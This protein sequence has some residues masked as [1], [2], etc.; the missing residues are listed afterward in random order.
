[1]S[2]R[3][4]I[5]N[6]RNIGIM[7]HIDAG[8]TTTTERILYYTG[9]SYKIG[10]VHD[11]TAIMDWMAQEQERG[12]TITSAA[13]TCVWNGHTINIIDTPGHVDFTI[14]VER[15]LRVLDGAIAVLDG[16]AGVEPQTETVWRQADKYSVP[17]I[18]FVNKMDRVGADFDACVGMVQQRLEVVPFVVQR[19]I[20]VEDAFAGVIDLVQMDKI[21]WD[22]GNLGSTFKR[23][24]LGVEE[25]VEA[26]IHREALLEQLSDFDDELLEMILEGEEPSVDCL[27][28]VLRK[29]TLSGDGV[30]VLC[31]AAFK[32]KGVQPLLDA[33]L[34]YLPSPTDVPPVEGLRVDSKT[35]TD[36]TVT[37]TASDEAPFSALA[38]KIQSDKFVDQL[39]YFRVYSG[40]LAKGKT[41][42]N[43]GKGKRERI[44]RLLKMHANQQEEV[45]VCYAGDIVAAVGLRLVTTGDTLC[46]EKDRIILE[47]IEFPDPVIRI[48]IEPRTK[49]DQDKLASALKRLALED[50]SFTVTANSETGQ[51]V[52]AGMGELHLE[53]IVDRLLREFKVKANR[54][55]PQV[56]YRE[57]VGSQGLAEGKFVRQN[58]GKGQFGHCWLTVEPGPLGSGF[59]FVS[60]MEAGMI[61]DG[62]IPAIQDGAE[63]AYQSGSLAG[64]PM[65]DVLVTLTKASFHEVDSTEAAFKIAGSIA[66]RAACDRATPTLLEPLMGVEIV[67]PEEFLGDVISDVNQRGGEVRNMEPRGRLQAVTAN[68]PL[69][70][71]FG[72]STDLRSATQ[73]RATYS[74]EFERYSPV[75]KRVLDTIVGVH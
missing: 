36:V 28:A 49:V 34:L 42:Y 69:S 25:G 38:F 35:V 68:I 19:P 50:P 18:L 45:A 60:T 27:N 74:M 53:I 1:M 46:S 51:T 41:V 43:P 3:T 11:G 54:G 8:K 22:E 72:Y 15:S 30:P 65:V 59:S 73:G 12:I 47:R 20:G 17:R 63:S 21:L 14:E 61:P 32:N 10:E 48:A 64:Y 24:P 71:M 26:S 44:G 75:S 55:K 31:G 29:A 4:P 62:F 40:T 66:Y 2:R 39:T 67:V 57:T 70:R 6:V 16:V 33:V 9:R 52:I 37:R 56:A 23:L 7:A 58:A 5:A 13:T